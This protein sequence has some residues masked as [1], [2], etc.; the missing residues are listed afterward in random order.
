MLKIIIRS[1]QNKLIKIYSIVT[2][3]SW[4]VTLNFSQ[5]KTLFPNHK[6][7]KHFLLNYI[8]I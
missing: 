4:G 1:K 8:Y 7:L 2:Q 6:I 3:L 5:K